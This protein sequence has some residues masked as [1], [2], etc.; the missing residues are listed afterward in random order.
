VIR[1][2]SRGR[3]LAVVVAAMVAL[4][5]GGAVAVQ[6]YEEQ[7]APQAAPDGQT[8]LFIHAYANKE[9]G[10]QVTVGSIV[11]AGP[12]WWST[13]NGLTLDVGP[14]VVL[15]VRANSI[16]IGTTAG[17][18]ECWRFAGWYQRPSTSNAGMTENGSVNVS[19]SGV[20]DI[21]DGADH[22]LWLRYYYFID[23]G[24]TGAC[25]T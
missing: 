21:S 3:R 25:Y 17:Y 6:A 5:L 19:F 15:T 9:D 1:F 7:A 4:V 10:S 20:S 8:K 18:D 2:N 13:G 24:R 12:T 11:Q 14:E 23:Y 16:Y 22:C